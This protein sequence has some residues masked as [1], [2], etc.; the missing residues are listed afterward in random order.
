MSLFSTRSAGC[1]LLAGIVLTA[2]GAGLPDEAA[3]QSHW[4]SGRWSGQWESCTTGHR[5]R[6]NAR[7]CRVDACHVQ[8][9]FTGTFFKVLPFRYKTRLRIVHEEPGRLVLS[10][11]R[12]LPLMGEFR[13]RAVV[14]PGCFDATYQSRRDSGRWTLRR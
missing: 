6:L 7:F 13:Y 9:T 14:T 12:R 2:I 3:A 4:I 8:A 5:G 11:S 10:G 1:L